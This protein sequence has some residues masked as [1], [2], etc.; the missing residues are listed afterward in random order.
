MSLRKLFIVILSVIFV[1]MDML[2]ADRLFVDA[3]NI[4]A[5]QTKIVTVSLDNETKYTGFQFEL[6]LPD[7]LEVVV[8][9]DPTRAFSLSSRCSKTHTLTTNR[10]DGSTWRVACFSVQ[11]TPLT[12]VSGP[13]VEFKVKASGIFSG[14]PLLLSDVH[15][16]DMSNKDVS[17]PDCG[18]NVGDAE[19]NSIYMA[20]FGITPGHSKT[21][22]VD[23]ENESPFT[24]FQFDILMPDGLSVIPD[25]VSLSRRVSSDHVLATKQFDDGRIR[26]VCFSAT[27]SAISDNS[28]HLVDI[29][30]EAD[31]DVKGK[32]NIDI[33]NVTFTRSDGRE[34]TLD[35]VSAAVNIEL[36]PLESIKLNPET[37][38][39]FMDQ[40][41]K[42]DVVATP[43]DAYTGNLLWTSSDVTVI[44]VDDEGTVVPAGH[45]TATV[46]VSSEA[47]GLSASCDISV[48]K[49]VSVSASGPTILKA[50]QTVQLSASVKLQAEDKRVKWSTDNSDVIRLSSNGLV[51]AIAVGTAV[52]T[53]STVGGYSDTIEI[54]VEPT[55]VESIKLSKTELKLE[56]N[57]QSR[58]YAT[59]YPYLATNMDFVW[60]SSNTDVASVDKDGL[61]SGISVGK[62]IITATA[63][64]GSGV[65][66]ECSVE[67]VEFHVSE[68]STDVVKIKDLYYRI[69]RESHTAT[70]INHKDYRY[71][72][73]NANI[74]GCFSF[75]E[76]DYITTKIDDN[77]IVGYYTVSVT[78]PPTV[79]NVGNSAFLGCSRLEKVTLESGDT[80]I[81]LGYRFID[82]SCVK[83]IYL[84][85]ELTADSD[86][87]VFFRCKAEE[88]VIGDLV[89]NLPASYFYGCLKLTSVTLGASLS[90]VPMRLF[91]ECSSLKKITIPASVTSIGI[92]AFCECPLTD[93]VVESAV[94]SELDISGFD[95][96]TYSEATLYVPAGCKDIYSQTYPWSNFYNIEE[97]GMSGV[98]AP[99][100]ESPV[101][102]Y[103]YGPGG[104]LL[105]DGAFEN[106]PVLSPGVYIIIDKRSGKAVKQYL[107]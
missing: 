5:G 79:V 105:Y 31:M 77:A 21:V 28:G 26:V 57:E 24:A 19:I 93:I 38:S 92:Q 30:V 86:R 88:I 48:A 56:L 41:T 67:V 69:D 58:L 84:G 18:F 101:D 49:P 22:Y 76:A 20:D 83:S 36:I 106:R 65:F 43:D 11:N 44:S 61:V 6:S 40:K 1:V 29:V 91:M 62:A 23:L 47:T 68:I 50:K 103:I 46:T 107:K 97:V 3:F 98:D 9:Q 10:L 72:L 52:V 59:V 74:L 70:L 32:Q 71:N 87:D 89:V 14:G 25:G 37:L 7:G 81:C 99:L 102:I 15:C 45:G 17:L 104:S 63:T 12:G 66:A 82:T 80:P 33:R 2:A 54:I 55:P 34:Y 96:T 27:N 75:E 16:A 4:E 35:N 100:T 85:R 73:V 94:P 42:L 90:S 39:M 60:S 64:D 53:A 8:P 51:E 78:V 13:I 95:T